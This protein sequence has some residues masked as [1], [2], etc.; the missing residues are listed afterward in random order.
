MFFL[1][2]MVVSC[3][4]V[5]VLEFSRDEITFDTAGQRYP[6]G[7]SQKETIE[8]WSLIANF[9]YDLPL[10]KP[11][12]VKIRPDVSPQQAGRL[13]ELLPIGDDPIDLVGVGKRDMVGVSKRPRREADCWRGLIDMDEGRF[14]VSDG[15]KQKRAGAVG[16][17]EILVKMSESCEVTPE[18]ALEWAS[19]LPKS[20]GPPALVLGEALEWS[21]VLRWAN[22]MPESPFMWLLPSVR[23]PGPPRPS[24]ARLQRP[25]PPCRGAIL[26]KELPSPGEKDSLCRAVDW[27]GDDGLSVKNRCSSW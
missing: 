26:L 11:F 5:P 10:E 23:G 19:K 8:R 1:L 6:S 24:H 9:V 21:T 16:P 15:L 14:Y 3:S 12:R 25:S 13:F 20:C 17:G 4:S 27:G 18:T 7:S 2:R 22:S